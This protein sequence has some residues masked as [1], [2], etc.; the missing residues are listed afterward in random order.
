MPAQNFQNHAR[1]VTGFHKVAFLLLLVPFVF[2]VYRAAT[3][4]SVDG[5]MLVVFGIGVFMIA[6]YARVFAL[7][8]QDRVIA[9]EETLRM[10]RVFPEDLKSQ[11]SEITQSQFVALR[12]ASDDELVELSR[13]VLGGEFPDQKSI[14]AAV[15][16]WRAD[17][18]R[19]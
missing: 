5:L 19:V 18:R 2:W 6:F 11:I 9:L 13:R 4:F 12:F 10:E 17:H 1:L 15:K 14:K 16:N 8:A 7:G 3:S